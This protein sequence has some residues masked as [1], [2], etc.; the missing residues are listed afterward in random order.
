LC[1]YKR[2]GMRTAPNQNTSPMLLLKVFTRGGGAAV[3]ALQ[4]AAEA[5]G[6]AVGGALAVG[7]HAEVGVGLGEG[8]RPRGLGRRHRAAGQPPPATRR[9]TTQY[10]NTE[11]NKDTS[12]LKAILSKKYKR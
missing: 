2:Y 7:H 11:T 8:G 10:M 4:G 6:V 3:A 9:K 1:P 12:S 5:V